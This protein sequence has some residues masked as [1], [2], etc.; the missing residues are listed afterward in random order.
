[1]KELKIGIC[2][3]GFMG[4]MHFDVFSAMKGVKV[5]AVSTRD[6]KKLRGDWSGVGGNITGEAVK[7]DL[8]GVSMYP[9]VED[10]IKDESVDVVDIC[11]PTPLHVSVAR[12]ALASGK[13]TI[14]EKPLA[15]NSRDA[16]SLASAFKRKRVPFFI[17]HCIRFW[18]EYAAAKKIVASEKYGKVWQA[19]FTRL[20]GSPSWG[21][22]CWQTDPKIGKGA[23]LDLH[24]HDVDFIQY[25]FGM[26][27]KVMAHGT[28]GGKGAIDH[29]VASY[30]FK[31]C[32]DL[33]VTAE[34]GW[35]SAPGFGFSMS[36]RI[37]LEKGTMTFGCGASPERLTVYLRDGK[38]QTPRVQS[39]DGYSRELAYFV[40]CLR[41]KKEP[42]IVTPDS[43]AQ[44]I[45]L[46]EAE[47][48]SIRTGNKWVAIGSAR[49]DI[50]G[51]IVTENFRDRTLA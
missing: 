48:K 24:V 20:A 15:L 21:E 34:G 26:P 49:D 1:M 28:K 30:R 46:V 7:Q 3:L 2:G 51:E 9:D 23:A 37:E 43:A 22:E 42:I 10:V 36:F 47:L 27:S 5:V 16:N 45:R 17:A 31:G 33:V 35:L 39:G 19:S 32:R 40:D 6:K 44:A 18:P 4:K 8:T 38:I 11:L 41:K 14:C 13:P 25:M 29:I 50:A 12:K